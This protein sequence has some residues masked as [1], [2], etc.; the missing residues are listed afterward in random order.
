MISR[1]RLYNVIET[2]EEV[3]IPRVGVM[4][5]IERKSPEGEVLDIEYTRLPMP[6]PQVGQV[7]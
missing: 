7:A 6:T 1:I 5:R 3:R 4:V 2:C